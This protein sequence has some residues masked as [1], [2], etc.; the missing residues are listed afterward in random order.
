LAI[1]VQNILHSC[2]SLPD[3]EKQELASEILRRYS[4]LDFSPFSDDELDLNAEQLFLERDRR[5]SD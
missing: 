4:K 2:E 5:E 1:A 3:A